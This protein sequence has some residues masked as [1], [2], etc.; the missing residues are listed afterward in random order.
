MMFSKLQAGSNKMAIK[1][2]RI[3]P[4]LAATGMATI[5]TTAMIFSSL[6]CTKKIDDKDTTINAVLPANVKGLDPIRAN[7]LYSSTVIAQIFEGLLQYNYLKRPY[8]LEGGLAEAMPTVTDG[9]LTHTF[10]IKKG[11]RFQDNAAF[12]GGKGRELTAQDFIYSFKRLADPRNS[13]EG[14]WIFDGKI[15]GL[16][17]WADNVKAEK[18][19]YD[20]AIEGLQAPDKN[21]LVIKL[22]KPYYQLYYVLAMS[23]AGVVPR[24][25]I[26]K[27]GSEFLNN[28]VGTGPFMLEKPSDWVR[29]SK[30]TLKRNPNW[31][32][33]AYPSEGEAGDKE[34]GLLADAGKPMPFAEKVVFTELAE[35]QPRWQNL[36]KGNFDFAEIPNDNFESAVKKE[37]PKELA[38][39]LTNKAMRLDITP[40]PDV[41]YFGFNMKDTVLGKNKD[42]RHAMSL[43]QDVSTYIAKFLN[44]RGVAAQGPVPPGLSSYDADFKN[45]WVQLNIEKAKEALKKAGFP[46]GKGLPEFMLE[47]LADAKARQQAD[48]FSQNMAAIGV[49]IRISQNTWPQFQDKIKTGKA[50]IFG[51]AWSADYPDAQNFYQLFYSKNMSPGPNDSSFSNPEFDKLY[52][53]SLAMAPSA[54]RDVLYKKMRDI[55][56]EESP[57]I[58]TAHR[59]AYRVVHG[60]VNNFKWND[61]QNDYFKYLRVDPKKRAELKAKL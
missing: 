4:T 47:T 22:N 36:M 5:M 33:E 45:Q 24:E 59:V 46:D 61:I 44:G 21:T 37:N 18:A 7:D 3:L 17:E 35:A 29:N 40:N 11:V 16:N 51:I 19:N 2:A 53:Q 41:T 49:K 42:L 14:F 28:P 30:I 34:K 58:F 57:W 39:D 10:K 15:K 27:Y 54:E 9:G 23:F 38:T 55:V 60:W 8:A 43:A 13:S 12:P 25:A 56:V 26:E 50:Q 20:T 6:G 1:A 32:G 52:E 31:R 48:F